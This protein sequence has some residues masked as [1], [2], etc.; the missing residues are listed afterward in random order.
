LG[1]IVRT[2]KENA[3]A[4]VVASKEI[5]IEVNANK[6]KYMRWAGHVTRMGKGEAYTGFW[7]GGLKERDRLEDPGVDGRI[8]LSWIFRKWVVGLWTELSWLRIGTG[9]GHF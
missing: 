5:G 1:G 7:C 8:I 6:T 4:L 9:G 2:V 3:E